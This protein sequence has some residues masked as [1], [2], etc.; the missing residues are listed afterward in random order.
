VGYADLVIARRYHSRIFFL[1]AGLALCVSPVLAEHKATYSEKMQM[2][3]MLYFN[4]DVDRAIRAFEQAA[5]LNQK[6]AEPHTML[7]QLYTQKGGAEYMDKAIKECHEVLE[8]K[9]NKDIHLV[10]GN[11]LRN[12][13]GSEPDAAKQKEKLDEASKE[14]LEAEKEGAKRSLCEYTIGMIDLQQGNTDQA[15]AHV[16][17][18][19]KDQPDFADAHLVHGVLMFKEA[20][21]AGADGKPKDFS[22]PAVQQSLNKVIDELD[23]AIKQ[24]PK[25]AEAH[26]T[27]AEILLALG[28]NSEAEDEYNKTITDEPRYSQAWV[29][30]GSIEAQ[31]AAKETEADKQ[32]VHIK[33]AREAF[34]KAKAL[35]PNDKNISYG[36][37]LLLE[38]MGLFNE[39]ATEFEN[40]MMLETDTLTKANIQMHI[41]QLRGVQQ[42]TPLGGAMPGV[43]GVGGSIFT[44]GALS[45]PM[46]NLIQA[47]EQDKK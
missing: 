38:K 29:G 21:K 34:E 10:L 44:G 32:Q 25:N 36:L 11:L 26:N 45:I 40:C 47:P 30:I 12:A 16:E 19:I 31:L 37:A 6:A 5:E 33:K 43:P 46:K 24:K 14:I 27:K 13:A 7:L 3:Q 2:G 28:K 20:T 35:N 4:G 9:P 23:V 1:A 39:A 15:S 42:L 18:A 22:D 17:E 41:Q 8:R